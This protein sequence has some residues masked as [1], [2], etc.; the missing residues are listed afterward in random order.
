MHSNSANRGRRVLAL[1]GVLILALLAAPTAH[2]DVIDD[3]QAFLE[4]QRGSLQTFIDQEQAFLATA[5]RPVD[6]EQA[7]LNGQFAAWQRFFDDSQ[8]ALVGAGCTGTCFNVLPFIDDEQRF[9]DSQRAAL[10]TF[11]DAE[12]QFVD[13]V[14]QRIIDDEQAFLNQQTEALQT[15]TDDIEFFLSETR[16]EEDPA[17]FAALVLDES[18]NTFDPLLDPEASLRGGGTPH[19]GCV[20]N[21]AHADHYSLYVKGYMVG[22][23]YGTLRVSQWLEHNGRRIRGTYDHNECYNARGT[24]EVPRLQW[25]H[26][27]Y[28][29]RFTA[30]VHGQNKRTHN[31]EYVE[32]LLAD[33]PPCARTYC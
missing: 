9:L 21:S 28:P 27:P 17:E 16:L 14:R 19:K 5:N 3:E 11:I 2:A 25:T 1:L 12:Q 7:F 20:Y 30:V 22:C 10:Q 8:A 4:T 18:W 33:V 32:V 26:K 13:A 6:D 23:A 24:C 15:F 29:G 31:D